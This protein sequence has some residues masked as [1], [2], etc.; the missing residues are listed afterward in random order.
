MVRNKE[1]AFADAARVVELADT[2]DLGSGSVR[3]G[4][5]SPLARTTLYFRFFCRHN[6]NDH[7]QLNQSKGAPC[8]CA[9]PDTLM[10]NWFQSI[11]ARKI[12]DNQINDA[13]VDGCCSSSFILSV[14]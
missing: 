5:S 11:C 7:Q 14:R 2:P 9:D 3:I 6:G 1:P 4:G 13:P 8:F 10:T 12:C